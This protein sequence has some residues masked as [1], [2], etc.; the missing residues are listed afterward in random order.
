MD[1]ATHDH[2]PAPRA[3]P[4]TPEL[5]EPSWRATSPTGKILT[6]AL[7]RGVAGR[8]EVRAAYPD[9]NLIRSALVPDVA[10]AR[11]LAAEW[12]DAAIAK[13]FAELS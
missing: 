6:C 12:K 10:T 2:K 3:E 7:Y 13:G 9:D 11:A 4:P 1:W 5:L 8:V